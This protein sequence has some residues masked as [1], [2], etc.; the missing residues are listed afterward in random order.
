MLVEILTVIC[1]F[2][3]FEGIFPFLN[4]GAYKRTLQAMSELPESKVRIFGLSSMI[5]GVVFL[6]IVR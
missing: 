4:P 5:A 3:V 2:L 1:L 6:V